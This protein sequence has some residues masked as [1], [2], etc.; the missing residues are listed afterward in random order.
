MFYGFLFLIKDLVEWESP[1]RESGLTLL[2]GL[3]EWLLRGAQVLPN[4]GFANSGSESEAWLP[5]P[6]LATTARNV[7]TKSSSKPPLRKTC[8]ALRNGSNA[9]SYFLKKFEKFI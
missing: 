2:A 4:T 6:L 7:S 8:I 1:A 3:E 5:F 9:Q